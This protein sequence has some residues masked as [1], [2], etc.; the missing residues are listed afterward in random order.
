MAM[1]LCLVLA[2]QAVLAH[3][4]GAFAD[5]GRDPAAAEACRTCH[6]GPLSLEEWAAEELVEELRAIREG[7]ASDPVEFPEMDDG[8]LAALA[9]ALAAQ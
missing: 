4:S 2:M 5:E 8:E 7:R 1:R 3:W 6:Q 9:K